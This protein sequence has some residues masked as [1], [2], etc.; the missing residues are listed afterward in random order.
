MRVGIFVQL[1][2]Q[3][4]QCQAFNSHIQQVLGHF[5][6]IHFGQKRKQAAKVFGGTPV[7]SIEAAGH[8][9][10]IGERQPAALDHKI[11]FQTFHMKAPFVQNVGSLA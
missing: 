1:A 9:Q 11:I 5:R 10:Q 3:Q 2:L 6:N 4:L 7:P 8:V